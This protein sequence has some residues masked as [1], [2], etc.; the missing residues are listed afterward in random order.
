MFVECGESAFL[1]QGSE[2]RKKRQEL[3]KMWRA[4]RHVA[5]TM[6]EGPGH[7]SFFAHTAK[8]QPTPQPGHFT[9]VQS[10]LAERV[11]GFHTP[12]PRGWAGQQSWGMIDAA[13]QARQQQRAEAA[14]AAAFPFLFCISSA[15]PHSMP[16]SDHSQVQHASFGAQDGQGLSPLRY[17]HTS[18]PVQS[19]PV[20]PP[21]GVFAKPYIV[22]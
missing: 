1:R 16:A 21:H 7:A 8:D 5:H 10:D 4:D 9:T 15:M 2:W 22:L 19:M 13:V 12:L 18:M 14:K 11:D 20:V 3:E 17:G 6:E